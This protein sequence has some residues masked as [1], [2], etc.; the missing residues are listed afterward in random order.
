M[1]DRNYQLGSVIRQNVKP[2]ALYSHKMKG[3]E[4]WYTV[5]E[6][7]IV[8]YSQN[9]KGILHDFIGSKVKMYTNHKNPTCKNFNTNPILQ[10]RLILK[11][12]IPY[13]QYI[14]GNK[15]KVTDALSQLTIN[16]SQKTIHGSTY[17]TETMLELCD[18]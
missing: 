1:D 14:P 6:K 3:P 2:I 18:I 15:N 17:T 16:G 13:I 5:T 10:W 8:K 7:G 4:T 12:Y 11:E 9:L